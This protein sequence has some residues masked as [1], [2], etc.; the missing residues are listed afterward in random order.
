MSGRYSATLP[1]TNKSILATP[2]L[3]LGTACNVENSVWCRIVTMFSSDFCGLGSRKK[4]TK[5]KLIPIWF[6]SS[7]QHPM[8]VFCGQRRIR[9]C[10]GRWGP[11]PPSFS[12]YGGGD[13]GNA[14]RYQSMRAERLVDLGYR[15]LCDNGAS[16]NTP[17]VSPPSRY[18]HP[19][20]S[21]G[22]FFLIPLPTAFDVAAPPAPPRSTFLCHP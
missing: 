7:A 20:S 8:Q 11:P 3:V 1:G 15:W 13:A 21:K 4:I 12:Q 22:A 16:A 9:R 2:T 5:K 14:L 6:A 19:E 18:G 17:P 10:G